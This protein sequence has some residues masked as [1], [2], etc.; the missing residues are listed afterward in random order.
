MTFKRNETC[1][2]L[3]ELH[4]SNHECK[5]PR[6]GSVQRT[7]VQ[8]I[9][10][11]ETGRNLSR[12]WHPS[13]EFSTASSERLCDYRYV[14]HRGDIWRYHPCG[15]ELL[16]QTTSAWLFDVVP[17]YIRK[18]SYVQNQLA[19]SSITPHSS[20]TDV[21]G[22]KHSFANSVAP[23][24]SNSMMITYDVRRERGIMG[25]HHKYTTKYSNLRILGTL[26][27]STVYHQ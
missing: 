27:L 21:R 19:M 24:A 12:H 18:R 4:E 23:Y 6:T 5:K 3:F 9:Y 14:Q 25:G 2:H 1:F 15:T 7:F 8:T 13:Y 10:T 20:T 22:S 11:G 26:P 16:C 17:D